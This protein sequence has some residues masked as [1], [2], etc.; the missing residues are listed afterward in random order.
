[1]KALWN[2][3]INSHGV[4]SVHLPIGSKILSVYELYG[5]IKIWV[6]A[7]TEA[8]LA[9]RKVAVYTSIDTLP[10]HPGRYIGDVTIDHGNTTLFVFEEEM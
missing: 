5:K 8:F 6:L 10:D 1:M 2:Y 3:E 4:S 9:E 7:N